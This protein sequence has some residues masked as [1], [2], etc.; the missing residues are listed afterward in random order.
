MEQSV[1]LARR[2]NPLGVD[3]IDCSSGALVPGRAKFRLGPGYQVPFAEQIRREAGC[4]P[5]QWE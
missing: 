1:E 5:G 4:P 2:L 3:L